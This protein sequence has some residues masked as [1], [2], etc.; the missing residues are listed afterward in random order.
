MAANFRWVAAAPEAGS[1]T[2]RVAILVRTLP[3]DVVVFRIAK[4]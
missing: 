2:L 3:V 1:V 4:L